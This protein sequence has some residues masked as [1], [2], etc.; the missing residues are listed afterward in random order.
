[1]TVVRP[2]CLG[3][4]GKGRRVRPRMGCPADLLLTPASGSSADQEVWPGCLPGDRL[5]A[6][7]ARFSNAGGATS[8]LLLAACS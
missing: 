7:S 1:M 6:S 3:S 5:A 2:T 8:F 4:V